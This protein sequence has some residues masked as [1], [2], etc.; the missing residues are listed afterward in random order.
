MSKGWKAIPGY[1]KYMASR[2]GEIKSLNYMNHG[3][4]KVL[5]PA[6]DANGYLRT[7]L[8]NDNGKYDTVK[9]HRIIAKSF[10]SNPLSKPC[11]NHINGLKDDNRVANLEW[12]TRSEN[13]KHAFKTGLKTH[14]GEKNTSAKLTEEQVIEIRKNYKYGRRSKHEGGETK[15]QIADRYGVTFSA[16]K[17]IIQG[18]T[19]KHLL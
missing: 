4:E 2:D 18:N 14:K 7:M 12:V 13:T 16:I 10:L 9:V 8:L 11:V 17:N 1:R 19:W 15:Q 6:H 5:K 3:Y